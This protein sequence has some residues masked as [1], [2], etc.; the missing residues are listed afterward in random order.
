VTPIGR[1]PLPRDARS[2]A[3]ARGVEWLVDHV[4]A[5]GAPR[6]EPSE[7]GHVYRLPYALLLAGRRGEAA[8]V[9]S[10]M[11]RDILDAQGDLRA[12]PMRDGFDRHWSS[13]P[14]ALIAL[15][16]WHLERY[17]LAGR[18]LRTLEAFQD[19]EHGGAFAERPD[20]RTTG[21]QDIFPTAQL[22]ITALAAGRLEVA[23]GAF[24]WFRLLHALQPELPHTL[25]S[26]TDG[27][28]LITDPGDDARERFGLVTDLT[29][30]RQAFYNP[31]IAAAFL[32]RYA[33]ATGSAEARELAEAFLSLTRE[34]TPAQFDLTESVQVCKYGWGAA[35]MLDLTGDG[36]HRDHSERMAAWFVAGQLPDGTWE[37][38]PFLMPTGA[39]LG[40][41]LEVTAEFV[42]HLIVIDAALEGAR[43][44]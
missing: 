15:A 36:I 4:G 44:H 41:R 30:P 9:L 5:D 39:T 43:E 26:A 23:D 21:R 42:Q 37:N 33:A 34:G 22:G 17:E 7:V 8:R 25:Y 29:A 31:G 40:V 20:L 28:A 18:M 38:S 6:C 3:I 27:G 1:D 11:E 12:G 35:T 10:W 19:P 16:A 2:R 24:R 32:G 14:L 13:Y